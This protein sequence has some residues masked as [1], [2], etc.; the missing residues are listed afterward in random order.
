MYVADASDDKVY[1]YNMPDAIDARL[2]SLTLSGV[3]IGEFL[4]GREEYEGVAGEGVAEAT[5]EAAAMQRR[6]TVVI[7]PPDAD[8]NEANGHQVALEK[9]ETITVTVTSADDSRRKVYRVRFPETGWDPARDPWPHCLRG[10]LSEGFS[11][12]VYEGGSV[13]DLAACAERRDIVALYALHEGVY[14]SY[15]LGAPDFVNRAFRELFLDGLPVFTALTAESNGPPSPDP[16]GD[17]LDDAGQQPWPE[18]LRGDVAPGFS[19]VVYERGSVEDLVACA[20][21]RGISALYTL[22]EREWLS[23]ILE[24]PE[25]ANQPFRELFADGLPAITPL[26]VKSDGPPTDN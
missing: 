16:F 21:E 3:D 8:G 24:A 15:L 7:D 6:T 18:C 2:A 11:L 20:A 13:D 12:V 4:P 1:S 25:F 23:Y 9:V 26:V 22:H 10:A 17:D 5:I 14:V 19:L